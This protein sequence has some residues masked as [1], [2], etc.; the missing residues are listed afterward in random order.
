[1]ETLNEV[2]VFEAV[3]NTQDNFDQCSER[4]RRSFKNGPNYQQQVSVCTSR[5]KI[6][7]LTISIHQLQKSVNPAMPN[8][9]VQTKLSYLLDRRN[10]EVMKLSS[11]N[12]KL[13]K[14]QTKTPAGQSMMP[15]KQILH[16]QKGA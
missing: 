8:P 4:C 13:K 5:C 9:A 1:M 12:N 16:P 7:Q 3:A 11:Y 2:S 14:R 6:Q 10:K 15:A